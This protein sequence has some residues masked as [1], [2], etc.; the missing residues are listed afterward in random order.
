MTG[1]L[2]RVG[3]MGLLARRGAPGCNP[4]VGSTV[5]SGGL[6]PGITRRPEPFAEHDS[7]RVGGRVH[8]VVGRRHRENRSGRLTG[9]RPIQT[10]SV[11]ISYRITRL[12]QDLA[13]ILE[14]RLGQGAFQQRTD[15]PKNPFLRLVFNLKPASLVEPRKELEEDDGLRQ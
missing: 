2:P 10:S 12:C 11:F 1:L 13:V 7:L 14:E 8:A 3:W 6:T 9:S 5:L 4:C 15:I